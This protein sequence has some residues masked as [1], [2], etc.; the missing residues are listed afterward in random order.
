MLILVVG[1]FD[2]RFDS[3]RKTDESLQHA[4][5][6]LG[7]GIETAWLSTDAVEER[8]LQEC[9]ALLIAPGSPYRSMEGAL[10]A[11]RFAREQGVP[12]LATC[13]GFQHL[14]IEYARNVLGVGD[15]QHAEYDPDASRLFVHRLPCSLK[16]RDLEVRLKTGSLAARQYGTG[17][18]MEKYYCN[19]GVNPEFVPQLAAGPLQIVGSDNEGEV[20]VV[21]WPDHPFFIGTLFVPQLISTESRPHPLVTGLLRAAAE[22]SASG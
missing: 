4:A 2:P 21:E 11:I 9:E 15:A 14:I 1:D 10:A 18:A 8:Q 13:G 16:G 19:F 20:R 17:T 5:A 6:L 12:L 22:R 7:L 3:H